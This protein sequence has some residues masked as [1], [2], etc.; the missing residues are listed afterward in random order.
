MF[1]VGNEIGN[2]K[3][4]KSV[5]HDKASS[6]SDDIEDVHNSSTLQKKWVILYKN[7]TNANDK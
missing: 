2:R 1:E 6:N 5:L 3:S 4:T 7:S